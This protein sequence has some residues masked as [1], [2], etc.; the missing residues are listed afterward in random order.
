LLYDSEFPELTRRLVD[1]ARGSS[2]YRSATDSGIRMRVR[3]C[4]LRSP[5]NRGTSN[6]VV[7]SGNVN[8]LNVSNMDVIHKVAYLRPAT[9]SRRDGI[10]AEASENRDASSA[11]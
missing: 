4:A 9:L 2:S 1:E 11:T 6:C 5:G 7:M 8:L 10:A 3:Y